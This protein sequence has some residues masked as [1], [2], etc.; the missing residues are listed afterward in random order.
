M[1]QSQEQTILSIFTKL[2]NY[3]L[4]YLTGLGLSALSEITMTSLA[5]GSIF[6]G[7]ATNPWIGLAVFFL[8]HTGIKIVNAITGALVQS[9]HIVAQS[10]LQLAQV[11]TAQIETAPKPALDTVQDIPAGP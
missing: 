10:G 8:I 3:L 1:S 2:P 9:G 6:L 11:F 7:Y 5:L 4:N